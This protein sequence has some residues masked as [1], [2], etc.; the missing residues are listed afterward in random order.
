M[1]YSSA[2]TDETVM[3][4]KRVTWGVL[5]AD[6]TTGNIDTGLE[7]CEFIALIPITA[8]KV[9][10]LTATLPCAGNA[11]GVGCESNTNCNWI[12]FGY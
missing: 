7:V 3:G 8:A 9:V 11:V 6:A 1:S 5:T 12:A 10:N 2:K 4:N